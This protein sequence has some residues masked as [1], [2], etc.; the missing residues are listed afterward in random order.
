MHTHINV[1]L[2]LLTS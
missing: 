2:Y 1:E